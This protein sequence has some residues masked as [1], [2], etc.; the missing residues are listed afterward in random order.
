MTVPPE[1][2]AGRR[3]PVTLYTAT[4]VARLFRVDPK[5]VCRWANAGRLSYLRTPG[6]GLRFFADEV[7]ALLGLA[8]PCP[9]CGPGYR[10]GDD[11]CRHTPRPS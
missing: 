6:G 5:T 3:R 9:E 8:K 2:A 11:G 10:Y 1:L 4:E 7:Q